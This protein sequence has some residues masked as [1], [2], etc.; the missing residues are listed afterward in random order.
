MVNISGL[1]LCDRE[2]GCC[3]KLKK[4][5]PSEV[6]VCST[7]AYN[8]SAV[9]EVISKSHSIHVS[10]MK[11]RLFTKEKIPNIMPFTACQSWDL[12]IL[13]EMGEECLVYCLVFLS[14]F[15]HSSPDFEKPRKKMIF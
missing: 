6:V 5:P 12:Q 8:D 11:L 9:S 15:N 4:R 10:F 1:R 7:T 3:P 14:P 2:G 13:D